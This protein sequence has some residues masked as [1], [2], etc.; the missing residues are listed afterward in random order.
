MRVRAHLVASARRH[1]PCLAFA[2]TRMRGD[3]IVW[4][5]LTQIGVKKRAQNQLRFAISLYTNSWVASSR[6]GYGTLGLGSDT[7]AHAR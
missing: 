2:C 5:E 6:Q 3:T 4:P 7:A 1:L